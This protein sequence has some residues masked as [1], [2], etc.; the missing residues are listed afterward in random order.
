MVPL[1]LYQIP[2]LHW[3]SPLIASHLT[4][5]SHVTALSKSCNFH[6]R[7][8]RHIRK[9]LTDDMAHSIAVALVSSRLDYANSILYGISKSNILKLQRIQ[10]HLAKLVTQNYHISSSATIQLLHWL[11]IKHR[12]DFKLSTLTYKLLHSHTPLYLASTLPTSNPIRNLR[13]GNLDLLHQPFSSSA[14]GSHAF[15]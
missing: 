4:F 1:S 14:I 5:D 8:L 15:H 11:P 10:N 3:A 6:I 13:S 12:I 7:L 2:L 9:S